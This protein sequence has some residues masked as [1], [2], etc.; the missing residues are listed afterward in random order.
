MVPEEPGQRSRQGCLPGSGFRRQCWPPAHVPLLWQVGPW[1]TWC[2]MGAPQPSRKGVNPISILP[3]PEDSGA[4]LH[5]WPCGLLGCN[6]LQADCGQRGRRASP[7][8]SQKDLSI[9]CCFYFLQSMGGIQV[10]RAGSL[11][12]LVLLGFQLLCT[13][14]EEY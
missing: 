6:L 2:A 9:T 11:A 10:W 1:S 13:S 8:S 3:C 5:P 14:V 4:S 12:E 7:H